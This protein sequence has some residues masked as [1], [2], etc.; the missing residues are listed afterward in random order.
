M[1]AKEKVGRWRE[2][3]LCHGEDV[4]N[5]CFFPKESVGRVRERRSE[6]SGTKVRLSFF[7]ADDVKSNQAVLFNRLCA[8]DFNIWIP[9]VM[10]WWAEDGRWRRYGER[11]S[12]T[13][14]EP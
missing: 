5:L 8:M 10:G 3:R 6:D 7:N 13:R 1:L 12:E 14:F 9:N 11:K 2:E 4:G